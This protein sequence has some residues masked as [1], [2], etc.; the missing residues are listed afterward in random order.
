[1]GLAY[2]DIAPLQDSENVDV[3][4]GPSLQNTRI[5]LN[6]IKEPLSN[7]KVRQALSYAF[8]YQDVIDYCLEG[9]A[10]QSVGPIPYGLWGHSEE[11]FQ[12]KY[13]LNKAK[14]LLEEAGYSEG[15]FKLLLIY[16]SARDTQRKLAE[17]YKASLAKLNIDLEIRGMTVS[18]GYSIARS[19]NLDDRQD[20]FV[21]LWW[22]DYASPAGWLVPNFRSEEEP[23][24]NISYY[25]NKEYDSL[26]GRAAVESGVDI[27]KSAKTYIEAQKVLVEDVPEI[28][29][30]DHQDVYFI[31]KSFK[32]YKGNMAY[33]NVVFF[34]DTYREQ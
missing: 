9:H 1:M 6:T 12:Y 10:R 19:G 34:Y 31:S 13:D 16:V 22:P 33:P 18:A 25:K 5:C 28:W 17:L 30:C 32:G 29:V 14:Q 15:G 26:V 2:E 20:L 4:I 8:P 24:A 23:S 3:C 11:L 27:D 21:N 7:K